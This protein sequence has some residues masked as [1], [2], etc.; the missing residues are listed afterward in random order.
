MNMIIINGKKFFGSNVSINNNSVVIDGKEIVDGEIY[1]E[2]KINI[3]IDGNVQNLEV[4]ACLSIKVNGNVNKLSTMSG[5]VEVTGE[6]SGDVSSTSGDIDCGEVK[7][8]VQTVSGDVS[9]GAVGGSVKTVSGDIKN[10]K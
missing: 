8:S 10:K 4:D 1:S 7:G 3:M 2:P 6:V 5:R 9:C